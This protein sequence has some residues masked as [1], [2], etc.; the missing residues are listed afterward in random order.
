MLQDSE[1]ISHCSCFVIKWSEL[2]ASVRKRYCLFIADFG[3]VFP[4][5]YAQLLL[6]GFQKVQKPFGDWEVAPG[7]GSQNILPTSA[8]EILSE[9]AQTWNEDLSSGN[10]DLLLFGYIPL[11]SIN[12]GRNCSEKNRS[13]F[14]RGEF[15]IGFSC[16]VTVSFCK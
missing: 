1:T 10:E 2:L 15:P 14:F 7:S 3:K 5:P 4:T 9:A 6:L 12:S 11:N 16:F 13:H 8:E